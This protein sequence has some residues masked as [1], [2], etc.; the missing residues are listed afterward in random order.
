[1]LVLLLVVVGDAVVSC[2]R[3]IKGGR[4]DRTFQALLIS[5]FLSKKPDRCTCGEKKQTKKTPE[6]NEC[7]AR[8][9][10]AGRT[11]E[12]AA[13]NDLQNDGERRTRGWR[14]LTS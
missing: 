2:V 7:S 6:G 14:S 8:I 11:K 9:V 13:E 4:D 5:P 3:T 10:G 1:M 12:D